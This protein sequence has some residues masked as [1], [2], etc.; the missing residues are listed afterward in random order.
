MAFARAALD[1]ACP[2]DAESPAPML[3]AERL[4]VGYCAET[5][6]RGGSLGTA[7][8]EILI[9]RDRTLAL[10]Q[11]AD[12]AVLERADA[13]FDHIVVV[14]GREYAPLGASY[15]TAAGTMVSPRTA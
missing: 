5:R 8:G 15:S 14:L 6:S 1:H 4:A 9:C 2:H 7:L 3:R 10:L 13:I 11:G 12:P